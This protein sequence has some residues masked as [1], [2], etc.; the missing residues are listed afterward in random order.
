MNLEL[1]HVFIWV[2]KGGLEA[3]VLVDAGFTEG[4][5][6]VHPGQGTANRRFFFDNL[7][8]ELIWV[9]NRDD[10]LTPPIR[11]AYFW[12]RWQARGETSSPFGLV[13]RSPFNSVPFAATDFSPPYLPEY[14]SFKIGANAGTLGEPLV[15]VMPSCLTQGNQAISPDMPEGFNTVTGLR[16]YLPGPVKKASPLDVINRL[17]GLDIHGSGRGHFMEIEFCG[18]AMGKKLDFRPVL[19][20][21]F[22]Y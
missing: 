21:R 16:V 2:D 12:E 18:R 1:D 5:G 17:D 10:T 13:F 22:F 4:E 11:P 14:M 19:P 7:M 9:E 6:N 15:F 8:L 20:L 3:D